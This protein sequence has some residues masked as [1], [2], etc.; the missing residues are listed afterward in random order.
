MGIE[1]TYPSLVKPDYITMD[2]T[3]RAI[4]L[5]KYGSGFDAGMKPIALTDKEIIDVVNYIQNTWE[6]EA[7]FLLETELKQFKNQ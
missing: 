2:Q 4:K 1:R 7:P 6:N 3:E 5:I